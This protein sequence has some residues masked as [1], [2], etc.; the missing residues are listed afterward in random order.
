MSDQQSRDQASLIYQAAVDDTG[1]AMVWMFYLIARN[2][3][4]QTRIQREI[5]IAVG[6]QPVKSM[7]VPKLP[8]TKRVIN[9]S[10]RLYPPTWLFT[11]R[12]ARQDTTVGEYEIKRKTWVFLSPF[13]T[14]RDSRFFENPTRFD[15]GRF[16]AERFGKIQ[17]ASFFPFGLGPR[18][19]A[20][21]RQ[22][23][24]QLSIIAAN[25]L[26]RFDLMLEPGFENVNP[27]PKVTVRPGSAIRIRVERRQAS[28]KVVPKTRAG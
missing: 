8:L 17:K 23:M 22:A 28:S 3:E 15:P 4:V 20:G 9:E 2:P 1:S 16:S 11:A 12:K 10:M 25:V 26:Q 6:D 14:Q 18:A 19:C 13:V 5:A 21:A 27:I 7:D 24:V